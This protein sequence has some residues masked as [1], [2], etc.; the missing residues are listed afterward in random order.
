GVEGTHYDIAN[1]SHQLVTQVYSDVWIE[2]PV[3]TAAYVSDRIAV[4]G[5]AID[6]GLRYDHFRT[7]AERPWLLDTVATSP[8]FGAYAPFPR[9]STYGRNSDGS[10]VTFG[11]KPLLDLRADAAHGALSPH[12]A[13]AGRVGDR[14]ILHAA[15]SRQVQLPDFAISF[16][17]INTDV[18]I[19][20]T[21]QPFGSN[22]G[23][24]DATVI[25]AGASRAL[26]PGLVG[27][28]TAYHRRDLT[29]TFAVFT[30]EYD[31]ATKAAQNVRVA[32]DRDGGTTDG[33]ELELSGR[34]GLL[35]GEASYAYQHTSY[36]IN[37]LGYAPDE[38][39]RPHA[40]SA[41]VT[42]AFPPGWRAGTLAGRLLSRT[43]ATAEL[44]YASGARDYACT[45]ATAVSP[46]GLPCPIPPI[47]SILQTGPVRLPAYKIVDI[48]LSRA[49][50]LAGHS[51][52]VFVDAHNLFNFR[53]YTSALDPSAGTT[54]PREEAQAWSTYSAG[55]SFEAARNGVY[56]SGTGNIDLTFG[57]A[58]D[59]RSGCG[60]WMNSAGSPASPN[61]VYLIQAEQRFGNG[62]GVFTVA[63]QRRASEAQYLL[64]RGLAAMTDLPRRI[65]IGIEMTL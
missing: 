53:N 28:A 16:A 18:Q 5:V 12:L 15:I 45:S 42:L 10:I 6:A 17:G 4:G 11:G 57:G 26:L 1:Y 8:T 23:F 31:P 20:N 32:Q 61:C 9:P 2:R 49:I 48:R 43:A 54:S 37:P 29:R 35:S 40:L 36:A 60:A 39:D 33:I 22:L 7:G 38:G 56:N 65:R 25:E 59:P 27:S 13:I 58:A 34:V 52:S 44:L 63:E 62:D 19:T 46:T 55:Y 51:F 50:D 41:A 14:T 21:S 47:T 24:L 3:S 30:P 64:S